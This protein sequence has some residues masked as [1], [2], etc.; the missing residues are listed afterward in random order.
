MDRLRQLIGFARCGDRQS[1]LQITQTLLVIPYPDANGFARIKPYPMISGMKYIQPIPPQ[2][3]EV[4]KDP[5]LPLIITEGE[6]K[7]VATCKAGFNCIGLGGLW[8]W[9]TEGRP[10][11]DIDSIA[12]TD[13]A[14]TIIPDSDVWY[15][16]DLMK[17]VFALAIELENRGAHLKVV[18]LPHEGEKMG[19]D[20]FLVKYGPGELEK[21]HQIDL[22]H[23]TWKSFRTWHKEWQKTKQN[24]IARPKALELL[25]KLGTT[26]RIHPA[27]DLINDKEGLW[28]GIPTREGIVF[29][30]SNREAMREDE[31]PEG[32]EVNDQGFDLSRFSPDGVKR[33]LTGENTGT[34]VLLGDLKQFFR[35]FIFFKDDRVYLFFTL[36]TMGTYVYK[37]FRVFPYISLRSPTK[38]CGKTRTENVF[39]VVAFNAG[40]RQVS[41]TEASLFREPGRNGGTLLLD[42]IEKLKHDSDKYSMV[43]AVINAGFE[44]DGVVQRT[45][46]RGNRFVTV[47]YP[48][49]CPKVLAGISKLAETTEGR[50]ITIFMER[51][52]RTEKL[53]R[54]S[55]TKIL[56]QMQPTW[57]RLYIWAL[58]NATEIAET[59]GAIDSLP[60]L[61]GLTDRERD[62]WEPLVSVALIADRESKGDAT[63]VADEIASLARDLS[64]VRAEIDTANVTDIIDVLEETLEGKEKVRIAPTT[65]LDKFKLRPEFEWV[66]S[67]KRLANLLAPL[68]LVASSQ[69]DLDPMNGKRGRRYAI[70]SKD[71][72]ELKKRYGE[73]VQE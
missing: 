48:V 10:I 34:N 73:D 13:R 2:M 52:L 23:T 54:F 14:V 15:R 71:L 40:I 24:K 43:Q 49:Y 25:E 36:W 5:R 19:L 35:K 42:E 29:V 70:R 11:P 47:S 51:K 7:T 20:D 66:K 53:E 16:P 45:E 50:A 67:A 65:L 9:V 41:P 59:Y 68:G 31:L 58:T 33:F 32:L 44:A 62:L 60:H 17:A 30:N 6:K 55:R 18:M 21:Q 38:E 57:D 61:D 28:Y 22:K 8:N 26:R 37:V 72:D 46:K 4:L 39:S 64:V 63:P 3:Q 1:I 12:W 56:R 27:Q 69:R